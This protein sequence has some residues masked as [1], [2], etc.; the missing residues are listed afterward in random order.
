M[1]AVALSL[2]A[3]EAGYTRHKTSDLLALDQSTR[4]LMYRIHL[5]TY[6]QVL[7]PSRPEPRCAKHGHS[8][9]LR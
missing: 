2:Q 9:K 5:M 6:D 7:S 3:T 4:R 1:A 8:S